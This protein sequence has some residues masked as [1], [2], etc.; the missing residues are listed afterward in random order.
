MRLHEDKHLTGYL[1]INDI[2]S[3]QD[4]PFM[5]SLPNPQILS[6]ILSTDIDTCLHGNERYIMF[7]MYFNYLHY[8]CHATIFLFQTPGLHKIYISHRLLK[9]HTKVAPTLNMLPKH[10]F[11]SLG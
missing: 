5:I 11:I 1:F 6:T 9:W 7:V 4:I 2:I 10:N 3:T 8:G